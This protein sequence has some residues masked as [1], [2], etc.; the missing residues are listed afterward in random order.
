VALDAFE[1]EWGAQLPPVVTAWRDAWEHVI[2]FMQFG[3]EVYTTGAFEALNRQL[4]RAVKT[5]GSFPSDDAARKV[6]DLAISSARTRTRGW[7]DAR[8]ESK[9]HFGDRVPD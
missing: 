6:I 7:T 4:R 1:Q 5:D 9:I 8:L 3:P 2:P